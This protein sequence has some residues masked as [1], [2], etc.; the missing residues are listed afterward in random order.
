MKDFI[1]NPD[2]VIKALIE[3]RVGIPEN[4]VKSEINKFISYW[5]EPNKSGTKTRWEMERTFDLK[6]R[7]TTWFNNVN[8]FEKVTNKKR[9][10]FNA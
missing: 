5:T 8:K 7:L 1:N 3:K 4:I 6:R 2:L 9:G 10:I